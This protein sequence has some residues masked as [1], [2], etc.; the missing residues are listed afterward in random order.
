MEEQDR[1]IETLE[2]EIK[3]WGI[4]T[5]LKFVDTFKPILKEIRNQT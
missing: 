5:M 2:E 1:W 4:S 3:E